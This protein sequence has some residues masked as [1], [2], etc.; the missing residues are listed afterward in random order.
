V[1]TQVTPPSQKYEKPPTLTVTNGLAQFQVLGVTFAG[2]V[3]PQGRV[4]MHSGQTPL[5]RVICAHL[6]QCFD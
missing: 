1:G 4:T 5:P 6:S 2:Y 3:T